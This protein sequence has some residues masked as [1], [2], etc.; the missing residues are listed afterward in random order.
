[1]NSRI[2]GFLFFLAAAFAVNSAQALPPGTVRISSLRSQGNCPQGTVSAAISENGAALSVLY[3]NYG[4]NVPPGVQWGFAQCLVELVVRRPADHELVVESA[5]FHG[6]VS[7]DPGA[8]VQYNV[9]VGAGADTVSAVPLPNM[10]TFT[11]SGPV[12]K[13]F[14]VTNQPLHVSAN[15]SPRAKDVIAISSNMMLTK[16]NVQANAMLMADSVDSRLKQRFKL[17]WRKCGGGGPVAPGTW[18]FL[19]YCA[20]GSCPADTRNCGFVGQPCSPVGHSCT[21]QYRGRLH[22]MRCQ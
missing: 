6:F 17:K 16:H 3:D 5:D 21:V 4:I 9:N 13:D 8:H 12:Q 18:A 22:S 15:C 20:P 1:M 10:L 7:L 2:T 14:V 11:W 19:G